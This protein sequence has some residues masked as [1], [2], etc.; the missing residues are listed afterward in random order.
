MALPTYPIP[1]NDPQGLNH[2]N[3]NFD[4]LEQ[5][6]NALIKP[7]YVASSQAEMLALD[8]EP[9][10]TCVRTDIGETFILTA[11]PASTL[12]NWLQM[13]SAQNLVQS[14]NGQIG[15]VVLDGSNIQDPATE[16]TVSDIITEN[17]Q[18]VTIA[19]RIYPG[20]DLS[21][22]FTA[23]IAEFPTVWAWMKSRIQSGNFTGIHVGD[24]I[25]FTAGGNAIKAEVAGIDTYYR[26]GDVAVDH[27]IDFISRDCWPETH[28]WNRA[29]YNNGTTVSPN[30]WLASEL[31]AWM[32]AVQMNVPSA[33]TANPAMISANYTTNGLLTK[34]PVPLQDVIVQKRILLPRRYTAGSLLV[35]DNAWDWADMGKLWIPSEVEVY[36][37]TVWGSNASPNQG[38]ASG[39]YVQYPIFAQ[40]MKRIKGAGDGGERSHWWL[41][42][43]RGGNS[44]HAAGVNNIGNASDA[45]ASNTSV[46]V[47]LCFRIA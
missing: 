33:A 32:N 45:S 8:A 11:S 40:N 25:P 42:S 12:A 37:H 14:V 22:K 2:L 19:D 20:V 10:N 29:N 24:Y 13:P 18:A 21:A 28:V 5:K 43:V 27:H 9:G 3:S 35:E 46:R 1:V 15:A 36:G 4:Y 34:L 17:T 38:Y 30:P 16:R 31:F 7:P 26:Y 44:T 39:G 6:T 47:P 41:S 23:E